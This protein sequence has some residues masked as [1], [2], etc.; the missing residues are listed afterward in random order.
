MDAVYEDQ[1]DT[2]KV[3]LETGK[4]MA[5]ETRDRY[6]SLIKQKPLVIYLLLALSYLLIIILFGLVISNERRL[7]SQ[8]TK[9]HKEL[10]RSKELFPCGSR[11]REWEYYDERCYFFSIEDATW[12]T[13]K[14]H[15]EE[16]NSMLVVI[17]DQAKQNFLQ[18]Q[19]RNQRFWIGLSDENT[20]GDW[21]WI[22]GTNYTKGFKNWKT[23]EP[24]D[25]SGEDCATMDSVGQWNDLKCNTKALYV[26]EKPLPS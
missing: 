11:S 8:V 3:Q 22:D 4:V 17:H 24:N 1:R 6:T 12:H 16:K 14:S 9:L 25:Q 13:A 21:R 26:C 19:T 23:G 5:F 15:C 20:E 2:G 10:Q 7:P 18:S